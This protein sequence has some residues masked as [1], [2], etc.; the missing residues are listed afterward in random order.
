M[1]SITAISTKLD[2]PRYLCILIHISLCLSMAFRSE[3]VITCVNSSNSTRSDNNAASTAVT[4]L[5]TAAACSSRSMTI[6]AALD[7]A[8]SLLSTTTTSTTA[9]NSSSSTSSSSTVTPKRLVLHVI[10]ADHNEG[11][12]V[13]E[14][15][16]VFYEMLLQ[17]ATI[18]KCDSVSIVLIGPNIS[19]N[20]TILDTG[21]S[22]TYPL[23]APHTAFCCE[24]AYYSGLYHEMRDT[25]PHS[26]KQVH[27]IVLF[28]AGIW[29]YT[30]WIPT[31]SCILNENS[32]ST[33]DSSSSS[34]TG[35]L[36]V[37]S[38]CMSEAIDDYD[39]LHDVVH[40]DSSSNSSTNDNS[41]AVAAV[42][43][44]SPTVTWLWQPELNLH[45]SVC[46]RAK[47]SGDHEQYEN[48]YWQCLSYSNSA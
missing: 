36:L 43:A 14:T 1:L 25:L 30:D 35:L 20:S 42:P 46:L 33:N 29:G 37:T 24:I 41:T 23:Q 12:T 27:M 10:G 17:L 34:K 22:C 26:I 15:T 19:A 39:V 48:H 16:A 5:P 31:L 3:P 2:N 13:A 38:Y 18:H 44:I 47:Q 40:S 11:S 28:N 4:T 7:R 6:L 32:S 9:V 45:R 8:Q 21:I